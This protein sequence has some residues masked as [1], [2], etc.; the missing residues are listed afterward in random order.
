VLSDT[1]PVRQILIHGEEK[2]LTVDLISQTIEE[3]D[4]DYLASS[5][6]RGLN[7]VDS[8]IDRITGTVKNVRSMVRS[9]R[10]D[11]W[12][13]TRLNNPHFYQH[14]AEARALE[15]GDEMPVPLSE[16][17]WTVYLMEAIRDSATQSERRE[18]Q[19][20]EQSIEQDAE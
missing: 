15:S 7:N 17:R 18:A 11:D 1:V 10:N 9:N 8:V 12:D 13:T 14:D 4:R 6:N 5:V 16:A 3:H 20:V 19:R 2:S